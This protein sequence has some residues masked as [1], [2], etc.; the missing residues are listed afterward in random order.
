MDERDV[1][2]P[3]AKEGFVRGKVVDLGT[4]TLTVQPYAGGEPIVA[5]YDR[6]FP[7]E[8]E[9]GTNLDD[10]CAL[11]F[12]NEGN[13][14][15]NLRRRFQSGSIY[16]YVANIL[17]S[18]N[19]CQ[20]V[21]ELYSHK[22][23]AAYQGR[24]LGSMP[25]HVFAI[26]DKT[27]RDMRTSNQSQSIIVSGES[28]SGKTE[29]T[30]YIIRYLTSLRSSKARAT[31][32]IEQ[33]L[34]EANPL[35]ESFGNAKT[36]RNGNSSRFGKYMEV[37]FSE[38][39]R[40]PGRIDYEEATVVGGSVSHYLLEKSRIVSQ[41]QEERNYHV[42]YRLCAASP[43]ELRQAL[44]LSQASD[45]HYLKHSCL[46]DPSIDDVE[47]FKSLQNSMTQV[48]LEEREKIAI[49]TVIGAVL[50]LGNIE[51]VENTESTK[52][53]SLIAKRALQSSQRAAS[54]LGLSIDTLCEALL[55][56]VMTTRRG[57]AKGT[58]I[59]VPLKQDQ[60]TK[61]RDA[62]AKAIYSRL[63]D[64]I[65]ER[66]NSCF[67]VER[68]A[69]FIG[70]LDI[71]GFEY[72]QRNSFEQFCIN[73][74]NE[75]LQQFFNESVLKHEQQLYKTEGLG[76]S[77]IEYIDN[78]DCIELYEAR[79][80]G[81]IDLLDEECRLPAGSVEHFT[82]VVHNK[83]GKHFRLMNP[84]RSKLAF[85]K[86][87]RDNEGFVVRHY[88][89]AVCYE[90]T[91]FMEKNNDA[92]HDN[93]ELLMQESS[94]PLIQKLFPMRSPAT[95]SK[96]PGK[97]KLIFA[98]IA[99]KFRAQLKQ[100]LE[101][102]NS[103]GAAF[104]RCLKP[105]VKMEKGVF[106]GGQV[107]SQLQSAGM[108]SVLSL[109]Q[110]GF[111]SR[112]GFQALYD[113]YKAY[114]P[115]KL[116]GLDPRTFCQALFRALGL[117]D[118]DYRFGLSKVFFKPGKFA[119]FDQVIK[120]DPE[121]I[122]RLVKKVQK[123]LVCK[124]WRRA[125]FAAV[126][127]IK[128]Q[129]KIQARKQGAVIVQKSVR[130]YFVRKQNQARVRAY[131]QAV[132]L[133]HQL[134]TIEESLGTLTKYRANLSP[135]L[136]NLKKKIDTFVQQLK[137]KPLAQSVVDTSLQT[138]AR[139]IDDI[140]QEL[141][142][143]ARK[144]KEEKEMERIRLIQES[145]E[146]ERKTR[147]EEERRREEEEKLRKERER[148]L[149]EIERQRRQAEEEAM[150]A[151]VEVQRRQEEE[152]ERLF[153]L[154][155]QQAEEE[156]RRMAAEEQERR[157]RE[158]AERLAQ[159]AARPQEVLLREAADPQ[160]RSASVSDAVP[161][162]PQRQH[163]TP[164]TAPSTV[165]ATAATTTAPRQHVAAALTAGKRDLTKW[166]YADLRDTI[167]TSTDVELLIACRDE[168][169]RRIRVYQAWKSKNKQRDTASPSG[170][171]SELRN[172]PSPPPPLPARGGQP[173][174]SPM[175]SRP[176]KSAALTKPSQP[177]TAT[178]NSAAA[179][180]LPRLAQAPLS[181]PIAPPRPAAAATAAP[182]QAPA[183]PQRTMAS[184]FAAQPQRF[185]RVPFIRPCDQ[186]QAKTAYRKK[187][188]WYAHFDGEWIARQMELH[189]DASPVLLTAGKDDMDMCELP[190]EETGLGRKRG[191]EIL[192][193]DFEK[194][195][196]KHGGQPYRLYRV[197]SMD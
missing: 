34:V 171:P 102:L 44:F 32:Q 24:S 83:H 74:C 46:T 31:S 110:T 61:G 14:L 159:D 27:Y 146:R 99:D 63:F 133:R 49:F 174:N 165:T 149:R 12:L 186:A 170:L 22:T 189:P 26:A 79:G 55:T 140:T 19:P 71:A 145:L 154:H 114:L 1:W 136:G 86:S 181:S 60:A 103:T 30:K 155:E 178:A 89:G 152:E 94:D 185:F 187:G 132:K 48:G 123:W 72:F 128:L 6:V 135:K 2:A 28:G 10:N 23:I 82:S 16:T 194:V 39:V 196:A 52:G 162:S 20:P 126:C 7:C 62:L 160:S 148:K 184:A 73:Y 17:L 101:K 197:V 11:M 111:P 3:H 84:R 51:F 124:R 192:E 138:Y 164:T 137:A 64:Y 47:G 125:Q 33:Q 77:H 45:F 190:L 179:A 147:E 141:H 15:D 106:K 143:L 144:E 108:V 93:L 81:L 90:T 166:K 109:M 191:A 100:L 9:R 18:V 91:Q 92:L 142:S 182:V 116:E 65:V 70:V 107:L 40:N 117:S 150:R 134:G 98:S 105:S 130:G 80:H 95:E 168:F 180:S 153:L 37:H 53:G 38:K 41:A 5:A 59:G 193:S 176:P 161:T 163:T 66:V 167:N 118:Y 131:P 88:A 120:S 96:K 113:M 139:Q 50:H 127:V 13:L 195:W 56:R 157:D 75:K 29:T 122:A 78:Q 58:V 97:S 151:R 158:L 188:W 36:T 54:L 173:S 119:E 121:N 21:P 42:F 87:M 129:R 175:P 4:S 8:D 25:P 156:A 172:T 112:T 43:P 57:G 67:P 69:N 177:S 35:L 169:H 104:I 68:S 76:L 183:A 115:A 85:Y